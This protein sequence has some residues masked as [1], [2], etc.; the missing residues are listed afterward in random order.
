MWVERR[1]LALRFDALLDL[2]VRYRHDLPN[3][4][5]KSSPTR[6]GLRSFQGGASRIYCGTT[7]ASKSTKIFES[8]SKAL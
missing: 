7:L 4:R 8:P 2:R 1:S 3:E 6:S 5:I